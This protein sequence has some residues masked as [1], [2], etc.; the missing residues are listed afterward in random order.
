MSASQ[1]Q[2]Q[3]L[4]QAQERESAPQGKAQ[5][6]DANFPMDA[7]GRT[8]HLGF[9][10]GEVANRILSVGDLGRA[11]KLMA[12]LDEPPDGKEVFRCHSN[13][14]FTTF[15]GT[16]NGVPVSIIST[17]MG[18]PN[19]DFVVREAR[20][21][22]EGQMA[23]ARLGTCGALQ[24]PAECGCIIVASKGSVKVLRDPD[25]FDGGEDGERPAYRIAKPVPADAQL[26]QLILDNLRAKFKEL[27]DDEM[28]LPGMNASAD[29]F[30]SSQGRVGLGFDDRNEELVD[31]L[32]DSHDGSI[33]S[34]EME[35]FH[36]LDLARCSRGT[37]VA[38]SAAIALADRWS[39]EF[40]DVSR[41]ELLELAAGEAILRSLTERPLDG[42]P[43]SDEDFLQLYGHS[44]FG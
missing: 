1:A 38:A 15:S 43:Q 22:V 27:H 29:S 39:N 17:M 19:M 23:F 36:L 42:A 21:V 26:S 9:K 33:L 24:R 34:L 35:T 28:V 11:S 25:A 31:R 5:F 32:V 44:V 37:V 6:L 12:L 18:F 13:R 3:E 14:N 2:A 7:E 40:I 16:F 20:A 10:R 41:I 4:E 8:Y 30:Y